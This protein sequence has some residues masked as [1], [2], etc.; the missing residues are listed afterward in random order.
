[1]LFQ[2]RALNVITSQDFIYFYSISRSSVNIFSDF[3]FD[4]KNLFSQAETRALMQSTRA[5]QAAA[6]SESSS[7]GPPDARLSLLAVK[8]RHLSS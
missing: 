7:E 1:M 4:Q 8:V 3:L 2:K 6:P 5:M